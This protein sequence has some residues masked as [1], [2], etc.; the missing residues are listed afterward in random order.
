M[1]THTK[2]TLTVV[3]LYLFGS[4]MYGC[5]RFTIPAPEAFSTPIAE[6][7][8]EK[9]T[10]NMPITV[11]V[12]SI[13]DDLGQLLSKDTGPAGTGREN[14]IAG[15]IQDFLRRQASKK[16]NNL[17]QNRYLRQQA[18]RVW[19]SL[20]APIRLEDT[21][22]LLLNPQAVHVSPPAKPDDM[23]TVVVGFDLK[24][25]I[26]PVT[27]VPMTA[28]SLP[29]ITMTAVPPETGF[30][31]ALE[32]ELSF[33]FLGKELTKKLEGRTY[34]APGETVV[35]EKVRLYGSGGS[36][37]MAVSVKGTVKGT[38]YL[39]GVPAYD[40]TTRSFMVRNPEYTVETKQVLIQAADWLLHT[41][42]REGLAD[43][44]AWFIGDRIDAEKGL[45]SRALNRNLNQH[46]NIRGEIRD[47]RL[48]SVGI[49]TNAIK[50][51]L[52]ADGTAVMNVF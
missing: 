26:V 33:D 46:M 30:H 1:F 17:A 23:V 28:Q 34:S 14:V 22:V 18:A 19:E 2:R 37:V 27:A 45:L 5:A 42:L 39:T 38:V 12:K 6:P 7:V 3:G 51:V 31:I 49:T 41:R 21:L 16:D 15:K 29:E 4:L 47:L 50:A 9:S 48:V 11:S 13:L 43:R 36:I 40:E 8:I 24:P 35:I 25:K 52:V 10:I 44:A 20:Q 32:S